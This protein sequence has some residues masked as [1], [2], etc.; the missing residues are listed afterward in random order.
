MASKGKL[1]LT[2]HKS[3]YG[4]VVALRRVG[5]GSTVEGSS[6]ASDQ[7]KPHTKG[8]RTSQRKLPMSPGCTVY[9]TSNFSS[10]NWSQAGSLL[11]LVSGH[12]PQLKL[13]LA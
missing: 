10:G 13:N 12:A 5:V 7:D 6:T 11:N 2:Q 8:S 4:C 1:Q 3:A 9:L